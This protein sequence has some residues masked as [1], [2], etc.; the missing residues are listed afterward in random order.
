[1]VPEAQAQRFPRSPDIPEEVGATAIMAPAAVQKKR[2][3]RQAGSPRSHRGS[4]WS[5]ETA[6]PNLGSPILGASPARK[7]RSRQS[8]V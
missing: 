7:T 8:S 3:D 2:L 6:H 1:M 4:E 5:A